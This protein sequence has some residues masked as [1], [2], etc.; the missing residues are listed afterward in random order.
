MI[1][2][3]IARNTFREVFK[4]PLFLVLAVVGI[5]AVVLLGIIPY[6]TIVLEDDV[7]MFKDV[8]A[9]MTL[10]VALLLAVLSASKVI[11]EEIDNK[12]MLTLMSKPILRGQVMLGKFLGVC[13][14]VAIIVAICGVIITVFAWFRPPWDENVA[15]FSKGADG[16]VAKLKDAFYPVD[17]H[18]AERRVNQWAHFWSVPPIMVLVFWQVA[19]MTAVSVAIS[20]R[21]GMA[22]NVMI[23]ALIFVAGHMISFLTLDGSWS[24][25]LGVSAL[26]TLVPQLENF[27][28]V[29]TLAYRTLGTTACPWPAV[30]SYVGLAGVCAALYCAA[31]LLVGLAVFRTREL[32]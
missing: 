19:V 6:F 17:R 31:A 22:L 4:S 5:V 25:Y 10:F 14:A 11:D 27:N 28:I 1:T 12:I 32:S 30:W 2:T 18:V 3:T 26:L 29:Q 24:A 8:A 9:A 21:L 23:C 15:I 20:T 13:A 7:K 16:F